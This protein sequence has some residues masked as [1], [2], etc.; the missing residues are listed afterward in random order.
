MNQSFLFF[1]PLFCSVNHFWNLK[2]PLMRHWNG[3]ICG[4]DAA[5]RFLHCDRR[6]Q[7][8]DKKN[9][10]PRFSTPTLFLWCFYEGAI[11]PIHHNV[12]HHRLFTFCLQTNRFNIKSFHE[13]EGVRVGACGGWNGRLWNF[14]RLHGKNCD[15]FCK[16]KADL[17]PL[18]LW[19][20]SGNTPFPKWKWT[21]GTKWVKHTLKF[22]GKLMNSEQNLCALRHEVHSAVMKQVEKILVTL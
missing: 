15:L 8:T 20:N 13:V 17:W 10:Q 7:I 9:I 6:E 5:G 12:L 19:W 14:R 18:P 2:T 21:G 11:S 16:M 22:W 3:C 4:K 1:L